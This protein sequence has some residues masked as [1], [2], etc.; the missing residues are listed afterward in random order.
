MSFSH[1]PLMLRTT[2]VASVQGWAF[3]AVRA[4]IGRPTL[5][6]S[7]CDVLLPI[8]STRHVG[9]DINANA[10]KR[11]EP[12]MGCRG[13]SCAKPN[14]PDGGLILGG[15]LDLPP[16]RALWNVPKPRN[17]ELPALTVAS[18]ALYRMEQHRCFETNCTL[19]VGQQSASRRARNRDLSHRT[20]ELHIT[21]LP[22]PISAT[23]EGQGEGPMILRQ[24]YSA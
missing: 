22:A 24:I 5:L 13:G 2:M 10:W 4:T 16:P 21:A 9:H 8:V 14:W 11:P 19:L 1:H 3:S 7:Q 17:R 20:R 6:F 18:M 12:W 15:L 23:L